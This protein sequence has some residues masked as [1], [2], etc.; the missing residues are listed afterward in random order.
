MSYESGPRE[1]GTLQSD[2]PVTWS[3]QRRYHAVVLENYVRLNPGQCITAAASLAGTCQKSLE[4][5]RSPPAH[6]LKMNSQC[7]KHKLWILVR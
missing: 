1:P 5:L 4:T 7:S 6:E 3:V 2:F